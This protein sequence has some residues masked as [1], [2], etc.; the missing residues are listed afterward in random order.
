[1]D[2]HQR[3]REPGGENPSGRDG[4][5]ATF[6]DRLEQGGPSD[7]ERGQPGSRPIWVGVDD[8][9]RTEALYSPGQLHLE[10]ESLDET[11][12]V[13]QLGMD[14]LDGHWSPAG[15]GAEIDGPHNAPP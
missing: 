5:R 12:I 4:Q 11:G 1:M 14:H 8:R 15:R 9:S 2:R 10:A 6:L 7:I 13:G 3:L